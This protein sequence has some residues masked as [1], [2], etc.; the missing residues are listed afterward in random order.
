MRLTYTVILTT[1]AE[2]GYTVVVPA[3]SGCV[4]EGQTISEALRMAEEAIACHVESLAKRKQ[5]IPPDG[6]VLSFD[7]NGI[8]EGF[9]FRVTATPE[10]EESVHA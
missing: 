9:I 2:G 3:L 6:P 5:P 7:N 4:T 1:D 10:V 8:T